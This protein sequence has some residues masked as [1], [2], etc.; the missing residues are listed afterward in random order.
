MDSVTL[1]HGSLIPKLVGYAQ[2]TQLPKCLTPLPVAAWGHGI[3]WT[4]P[5]RL[6][7]TLCLHF[8]H[9]PIPVPSRR[10]ARTGQERQVLCSPRQHGQGKGQGLQR[11]AG[12]PTRALAPAAASSAA[13][14]SISLARTPLLQ[15]PSLTSP[16][17][18]W[19]VSSGECSHHTHC[20]VIRE[21]SQHLTTPIW[22][23]WA[24]TRQ[25]RWVS[26]GGK[27]DGRE[28][29]EQHFPGIPSSWS[30]VNVRGRQRPSTSVFLPISPTHPIT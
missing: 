26:V 15:G 11:Q 21:L 30:P 13:S 8:P 14:L 6:Q 29:M 12:P 2:S 19:S 10:A 18:R 20:P 27:N 9:S 16:Q 5:G 22:L 25:A 7:V 28:V 3:S 23:T 17:S 1:S 4:L 24:S